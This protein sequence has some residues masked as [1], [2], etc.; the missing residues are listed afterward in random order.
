MTATDTRTQ[1]EVAAADELNSTKDTDKAGQGFIARLSRWLDRDHM[2]APLEVQTLFSA[3]L[4]DVAANRL[5]KQWSIRYLAADAKER[6]AL[7]AEAS[8]AG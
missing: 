4:T 6:K 5:A 1:E 2:P 7:L 8:Y 3:R